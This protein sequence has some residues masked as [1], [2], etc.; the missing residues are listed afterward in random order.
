M[1]SQGKHLQHAI[2]PRLTVDPL[3]PSSTFF[4]SRCACLRRNL[5]LILSRPFWLILRRRVCTF[6]QGL[7]HNMLSNRSQ[8][9]QHRSQHYKMP[10]LALSSRKHD[11]WCY[12][13]CLFSAPASDLTIGVCICTDHDRRNPS[14][15]Q[16]RTWSW[17]QDNR[18]KYNKIKW[19]NMNNKR[20]APKKMTILLS[21]IQFWELQTWWKRLSYGCTRCC[22]KKHYT[23]KH[24]FNWR[25]SWMP[26]PSPAWIQGGTLDC[27]MVALWAGT[28]RF[29]IPWADWWP[30]PYWK[31]IRNEKFWSYKM[32]EKAAILYRA[33]AR[34]SSIFGW[35]GEHES[36][37]RRP[38][39][40]HVSDGAQIGMRGRI[41]SREGL[42]QWSPPASA[43]HWNANL[44]SYGH[45]SK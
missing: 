2:S 42:L 40:A 4:T 29:C 43:S 6:L 1:Q 39:A 20:R 8:H 9:A 25:A 10:Q 27:P 32:P 31:W 30:L 17:C 7:L 16:W 5:R 11:H 35:Q 33:E 37:V 13:C 21:S 28:G 41:K 34:S 23:I 38:R 19:L 36:S 15:W 3:S 44:T 22:W 18:K 24:D 14:T 45:N 26:S 12:R